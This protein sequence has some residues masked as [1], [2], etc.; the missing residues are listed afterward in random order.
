MYRT[1]LLFSFGLVMVIYVTLEV[2]AFALYYVME[3]KTFSYSDLS[4]RR[5]LVSE[6][7]NLNYQKNA[8]GGQYNVPHPYLGFVYNLEVDRNPMMTKYGLTAERDP[9]EASKEPDSVIVAVTG[10]SVSEQF[11]NASHNQLREYVEKL[12]RYAGKKVDMVMLGRGMFHQPQQLNAVAYYLM[13]GGKLDMLINLDGFNEVTGPTEQNW[14]GVNPT[15]PFVWAEM[16]LGQMKG[17]S[18][19][20]IGEVMMWKK[21]RSFALDTFEPLRFS[22]TATTL[23]SFLDHYCDKQTVAAESALRDTSGQELPYFISGP[24]PD[25]RLSTEETVV[26]GE[27][28]WEQGSHQLQALAKLYHFS[29]FHFLQP[30][31]YVTDSKP[32]SE[33]ELAHAYQPKNPRYAYITDAYPLL[34]AGVVRL[35]A[36][37]EDVVSLTRLFKNEHRTVYHD[38]CCHFNELGH[39]LI[40]DVIGKHITESYK[41]H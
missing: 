22:V 34:E 8:M 5:E 11:F 33:E 17:Q 29:Y 38:E 24:K 28:L 3:D 25:H 9:M 26:I 1:T 27:Q 39:Q 15:F 18:L 37:G 21:F 35:H 2:S 14:G 13:Q 6:S 12:P 16:F 10:G 32:L 30:D 20:K 41:Q 19:A 40:V 31:Q 23:W 4:A 7:L 36:T